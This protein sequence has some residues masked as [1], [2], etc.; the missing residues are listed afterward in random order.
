[1][2][3]IE[4]AK[5]YPLRVAFTDGPHRHAGYPEAGVVWTSGPEPTSANLSTPG[6]A[7]LMVRAGL[8]HGWRADLGLVV[9]DGFAWLPLVRP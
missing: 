9:D 5:Q 6:V 3:F 2:A 4:G 1:M 7:T 8:A